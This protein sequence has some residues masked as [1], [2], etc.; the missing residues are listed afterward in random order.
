MAVGATLNATKTATLTGDA[1]DADSG[2]GALIDLEGAITAA[3]VSVVGGPDRDTIVIRGVAADAPMTVATGGAEDVILIGSRASATT[4][5]SG[6]L[7]ATS[8]A[9]GNL[10]TIVGT[11]TV[12]GASDGLASLDLDNSGFA[13]GVTGTVSDSEVAGFGMTGKV[14]YSDLRSLALHLGA[15]AD[16]ATVRSTAA[17][18]ITSLLLGDGAD[19]VIVSGVDGTVN[20]LAGT[21]IL[22]GGA[23]ANTLLVDDSGD[24]VAN[25][26]VIG[27]ANGNQIFGFGMG[28]TDQSVVDPNIGVTYGNFATVTVKAGSGAD[29]IAIAASSTDTIV[30]A[31]RSA[32]TRSRWGRTSPI[33]A[34][35]LSRAAAAMRATLS[36]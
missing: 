27:G 29:A 19:S 7:I 1:G 26:G 17:A 9:G 2:V 25:A 31:R 22:D 35:M 30:D 32:R 36:R 11:L 10:T 23:G 15:G 33:F 4:N 21:L 5:A 24:T 6:E 16:T 28:G 18:T 3:A 8:N 20:S 12:T 14:V 34:A 13:Q